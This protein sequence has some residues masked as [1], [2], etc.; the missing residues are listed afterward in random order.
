MLAIV[1]LLVTISSSV[2]ATPT[3]PPR[4]KFYNFDDYLI[5]GKLKKPTALLTD[6][7]RTAKFKR[8]Q[9]LEKSFIRPLLDTARE[10]T[11]K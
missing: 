8:F 7:H 10:K 11:L 2:S 5:D 9:G 3:K 4:V 1:A 6:V